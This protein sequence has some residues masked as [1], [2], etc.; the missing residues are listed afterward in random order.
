[1]VVSTDRIEK[2]ILLQAP[3][4]RV[5]RAISDSRQFGEWFGMEFA[6]GFVAGKEIVGK[7]TA[8]KADPEVARAMKRYEGTP[9]SFH[10]ERI[11]PQRFLS[12]RWHPFAIE[13]GVD[14][15]NEPTTLVTFELETV[16]G[17]TQLTIV[18]SGFDKIPLGRRVDAFEANSEG[19]DM[20]SGLL[21]KYLALPVD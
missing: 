15:S 18:E 5:W 21:E 7:L 4:E 6:G 19:W 1:M 2:R 8:T 12:Y 14:Y 3:Q 11:E 9:L 16:A 13:P 17:G 10:I 20:Q